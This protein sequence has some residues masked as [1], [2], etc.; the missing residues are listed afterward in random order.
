MSS[1]LP[2]FGNLQIIVNI[3]P[4][5]LMDQGTWL[6]TKVYAGSNPAEGNNFLLDKI[7]P[8]VY[9][10]ITLLNEVCYA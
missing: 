1:N 10:C 2:N 7:Y 8:V 5:S 9:M 3:R 6:R 4:R